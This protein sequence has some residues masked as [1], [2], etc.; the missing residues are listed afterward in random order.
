MIVQTTSYIILLFLQSFSTIGIFYS[1]ALLPLGLFTS[2]YAF[3]NYSSS[4]ADLVS[5]FPARD[6]LIL[7][8]TFN[9]NHDSAIVIIIPSK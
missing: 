2:Y 9:D 8:I 3:I 6:F 4:G 7:L 5:F 1:N